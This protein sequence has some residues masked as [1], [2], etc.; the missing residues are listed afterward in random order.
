MAKWTRRDVSLLLAKSSPIAVRRNEYL[1]RHFFGG[2]FFDDRDFAVGC[3]FLVQLDRHVVFADGLEGLVEF[4]LATIDLEAAAFELMGD[5]AGG[6]GAEQG[7]V[8]SGFAGEG[9]ADAFVLLCEQFGVGL[10][11]GALADGGGLHL[12]DDGLIGG[13][14]FDRQFLRQ[15]EIAAVPFGDLNDVSA[16]AQLGYIFFQNDFHVET[17]KFYLRLWTAEAERPDLIADAAMSSD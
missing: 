14:R 16:G 1:L 15:Q 2:S 12:L 10:F 4:D 11:L 6:D 3:D 9:E 8:L 13:G 17:P 5:I 7:V